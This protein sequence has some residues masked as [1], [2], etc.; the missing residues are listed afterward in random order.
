M[1]QLDFTKRP[2][3]VRLPPKSNSEIVLQRSSQV[4][5]V[6]V[7]LVA[8]V[9]ALYAARFILTP[10]ALAVVF[11]LMLG[12]VANLIERYGINSWISSG[13]VFL[14]FISGICVL[15]Y[16]LSG[17]IVF[18]GAQLPRIWS[19]LQ[20]QLSE[21]L[22]LIHGLREEMRE[23][24]GDEAMR[25]AV[26]EGSPVTDIAY[27][28]PAIGAQVLL[29]ATS[30]YFFLATRHATRLTAMKLCVTRRMRWRVAHVFRD[31]ELL[32]SRYLLSITAINAGLALAV[33]L[34]LWA[35]GVPQP[36]L[37]GALAGILNYV[38]YVGPAVMATMLF[39]VGLGTFDSLSSALL[40]PI[41]YLSINLLE[42]Q[43]V[44]P[45]VIGRAMTLN[46]FT[47]LLALTFWIWIWGPIGGFVAIPAML[48]IIA[49]A[50][51]LIPT[52]AS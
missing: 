38:M 26:E 7:G 22:S 49:V 45:M 13:I 12:P 11:G 42:A 30:L 33:T 43:V 40:P 1:R 47:V 6:I 18:W 9:F 16:V 19:E 3:I 48:I 5:I 14:L 17:P 46:P 28:A 36:A 27:M 25:V 8:T 4:A 32:V 23:L 37:W 39:I 50:R 52:L 31:I 41:V 10:V 51:N 24:G 34:A 2:P 15:A 20:V 35:I 21:P 29:F 44:T